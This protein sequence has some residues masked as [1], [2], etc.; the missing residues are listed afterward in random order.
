MSL[1]LL[2]LACG[3]PD[4]PEAPAVGT[5]PTEPATVPA[6]PEGGATTLGSADAPDAQ[7]GRPPHRLTVPQL[8]DAIEAATG[9]IRWMDGDDDR[10][11]ELSATLGVAD[12]IER[13]NE[14]RTADLVFNKF[15]DDAAKAVCAELIDREA[16]GGSD[17]VFLVGVDA[18]TGV[19]TD[20]VATE[21]AVANALLRFHGQDF[22]PGDPQ[23]AQWVWLHESTAFVT[24]GDNRLAW[25]TLCVGLIVHPDFTHY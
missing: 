14:N 19:D 13:T 4:A 1:L 22:A 7:S 20:R 17:N 9:G 24:D 8:A 18:D 25:Q 11:E 12:F 23:L 6:L 2:L 10:F 21:A 16:S 5:D 3:G 15:V